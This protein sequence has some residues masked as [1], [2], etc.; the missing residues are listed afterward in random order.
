MSNDTLELSI[1]PE[2]VEKYTQLFNQHAADGNYIT[3]DEIKNIFHQS[4]VSD[5]DGENLWNLTAITN[6]EKRNLDEFLITMSLLEKEKN[7]EELPSTLPSHININSKVVEKTVTISGTNVQTKTE[8]HTTVKSDQVALSNAEL[9]KMMEEK[10]DEET[11]E[12]GNTDET[13]NAKKAKT[14]PSNAELMRML[15]E[16]GDDDGNDNQSTSVV[17]TT[18]TTE[19]TTV[20]THKNGNPS[21]NGPPTTAELMKMMEESEKSNQESHGDNDTQDSSTNPSADTANSNDN[22]DEGETYKFGERKLSKA[23]M[24]EKSKLIFEKDVRDDDVDAMRQD[25]KERNGESKKQWEDKMR[26]AL[27]E[28]EVVPGEV[29]PSKEAERY[30][31]ESLEQKRIKEEEERLRK[32]LLQKMKEKEEEDA[33]AKESQS[34]S[35]DEDFQQILAK[36]KLQAKQMFSK[37]EKDNSISQA[38]KKREEERKRRKQEQEA[39]RLRREQEAREKIRKQLEEKKK[40]EE[41]LKKKMSADN[42]S[43]DDVDSSSQ[44]HEEY[45]IKSVG[46]LNISSFTKSQQ[47][48]DD[49]EEERQRRIKERLRQEEEEAQRIREEEERMRKQLRLKQGA[50]SDENASA[51]TESETTQPAVGSRGVG[52]LQLNKFGVFQGKRSDEEEQQHKIEVRKKLE[53]EEAKRIE[54]E[55]ERMRKQMLVKLAAAGGNTTGD[56]A[57]DGSEGSR[58]QSTASAESES[59]GSRVS[60]SSKEAGPSVLE[61]RKLLENRCNIVEQERQ[62]QIARNKA[63]A[64]KDAIKAKM[65]D[66]VQRSVDTPAP[67]TESS[68][69]VPTPAS[70]QQATATNKIHIDASANDTAEDEEQLHAIMAEQKF[71]AKQ[72]FEGIGRDA[73]SR[74]PNPDR[75]IEPI[76]LNKINQTSESTLTGAEN[77]VTEVPKLDDLSYRKRHLMLEEERL[78]QQRKEIEKQERL[79]LAKRIQQSSQDQNQDHSAIIEAKKVSKLS[80]E[81]FALSTKKEEDDDDDKKQERIR[82]EAEEARRI[83]EE[84]ERMRK[85]FAKKQAQ[86]AQAAKPTAVADVSYKDDTKDIKSVGKL[87]RDKFNF[88]PTRDGEGIDQKKKIALR[89]KQE[90]AE[91]KRIKQEEERLRKQQKKEIEDPTIAI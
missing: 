31:M 87:A 76:N 24:E 51:E 36:S 26:T 20:T 56:S 10:M 50:V 82:K 48:R 83:Q 46:K 43:Q 85:Q 78:R 11:D 71:R 32:Q 19:I 58:R 63:K 81:R 52:R 14:A 70:N 15:E 59:S 7:E 45:E 84:E 38:E 6:I 44:Y 18:T 66:T 64:E 91:A 42:Q 57:A 3:Y 55:E 25:L 47:K 22:D 30:K 40:A 16:Q 68:H 89:M 28:P 33:A 34:D 12:N 65:A 13:N 17:E 73:G 21:S 75:K 90:A 53:E 61:Q 49:V 35:D 39:I 41:E 79:L 74:S 4:E 67:A 29:D 69:N 8:T 88:T 77:K 23:V 72:L 80:K 86:E 9:L 62:Q 60:W 2:D 37:L 27:E 54:E 5:T 1:P